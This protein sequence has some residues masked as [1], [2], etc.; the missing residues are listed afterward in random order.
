[1]EMEM[2]MKKKTA[3]GGKMQGRCLWVLEP[4]RAPRRLTL[5]F[6]LFLLLL[7]FFSAS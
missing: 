6:L 1:M 3:F 7:L 4:R 5:L 2:E